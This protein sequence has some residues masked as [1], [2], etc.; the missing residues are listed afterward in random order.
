[1]KFQKSKV[2]IVGVGNVGATTAYSI[3]NQGLCEE[4]VLIDVNKEKAVGEALDMQQAIHFMNRNMVVRA[5]DYVDCKDADIVI[6]TASAP[7]PKDSNDR[8][9]MLQPS[10]HIMKSIVSSVMESGFSGIFIVVSNPVDIMTYLVWKFSG[11]S[12]SQV[13]GSGT[14]LDTARLCCS[15]A[16]MYDLDSK[17]VHAYILGEHGD[18]EMVAWSSSTIGGKLLSD[19]LSDNAERTQNETEESLLEQTKQAGWE[20]FS[21]KGNT[22]YG[23]AASTTAI[24]KSILF[25][26]NRILPVSVLVNG[27]YGIENVY[28]SVP[29]I[30]NGSCAKETVEIRLDEKEKK[31]LLESA[32]LL[33]SIYTDLQV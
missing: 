14:A 9:E 27:I 32:A 17:S 2:V 19:V 26:E 8:L 15:L 28:L 10:I 20:I 30:L 16:S 23:I 29:T 1:M 21:R 12:A 5:G 31:A 6:I 18:S 4:I 13:I 7:M 3:I 11:L 33:K 22:C 24:V 25:N